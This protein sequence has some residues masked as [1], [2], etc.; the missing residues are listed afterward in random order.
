VHYAQGDG[1]VAGTAIEMGAI[2][3]VTAEVRKG[4]A[5]LI[6]QPMFEGGSQIKK[7][8]PDSF[9]AVVGY[10]F[11]KAGEVPPQWAYLDSEK[12]KPLTN[13]SNDVTLA[14]RNSLITM[15]DW[16]MATKGLTKEQALVVASV[17]CDLRISNVV[18]VPNYAVTTICPMEIFG[19]K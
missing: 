9:H 4:M 3:T 10:P 12:I 16:L 13:L 19:N 1:E 15:L 5:S 8:E 7:L 2:V 17:A 14:A 18:D 11:K 6:K